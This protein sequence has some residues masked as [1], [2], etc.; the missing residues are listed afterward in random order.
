MP[1]LTRAEVAEQAGVPLAVAEQLW[2]LLGFP[3]AEEH[4]T[5][6]TSADVE[7]LRL[8]DQL[9]RLGILSGDRQSALVRTWGR[10]FAR[11]AEWQVSLLADVAR[12]RGGDATAEM[13]TLADDVIPQ[14]EALQSYAWRRH[15]GSAASR[16][17]A[18][19]PGADAAAG[20]TSTLAVGFV[21]IVGYTSRS[22]ELDEQELVAWIET[23]EHESTGLVVDQGGRLIKSLGDAVMYVADSPVDAA[24]VALTLTERGEDEADPYPRVRAGLAY[25]EVVPRLG[26]VF[27]PVVNIASRLTSVARPGTVVVDAGAAEELGEVAGLRVQRMRRTSVKGYAKLQPYALRRSR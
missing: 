24:E 20:E 11:L 15:L 7:A 27:G 4:Q 13:L 18:D 9:M 25:G 26:D 12:E 23:F 19:A 6:F 22:K 21:D 2:H 5:A 8:T 1:T 10:A 16:L 17:L 14:V 3:H